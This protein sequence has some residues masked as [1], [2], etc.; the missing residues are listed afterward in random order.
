M[1]P[2]KFQSIQDIKSVEVKL[3]LTELLEFI[4][5]LLN[6]YVEVPPDKKTKDM[7][8]RYFEY[9]IKTC[10]YK[11]VIDKRSSW[12]LAYGEII[13]DHL[14]SKRN[15]ILR[16]STQMMFVS[17]DH[18]ASRIDILADTITKYRTVINSSSI[19]DFEITE[20]LK[21]VIELSRSVTPNTNSN[22]Y[23]NLVKI[24]ELFTATTEHKVT[25]GHHGVSDFGLALVSCLLEIKFLTNRYILVKA[26]D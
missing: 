10:E 19:A 25:C 1:L 12:L 6:E 24:V 26:K 4:F 23:L 13:R 14:L 18:F 9:L 17:D 3:K 21:D 8:D 11:N 15:E 16:N 2:R 7:V 20:L 22:D 5:L